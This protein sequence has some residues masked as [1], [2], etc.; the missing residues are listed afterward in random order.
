[1]IF[2]LLFNLQLTNGPKK[3]E[4]FP[5]RLFQPS[6]TFASKTGA[7]PSKAKLRFSALLYLQMLN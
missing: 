4:F 7:Y 5:G 2:S 3:L 6:L 1:M